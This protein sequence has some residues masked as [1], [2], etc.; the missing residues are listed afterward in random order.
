MAP[1]ATGPS[2]V[3]NGKLDRSTPSP[4]Y[5]GYDHMTWYVGNAKQVVSWYTTRMGFQ[6]IAYQGLETG[7]RYTASYVISN[8]R[9]KFV[10]TSPIRG[11]SDLENASISEKKRVEEMH[12][13]LDQHGDGVKD[14]AFEVDDARA[15]YESAVRKGAKSVQEPSSL[16]DDDGEVI[17]ATIKT[18]GDTTHTFVQRSHYRGV[19]L[20]SYR[21]VSA[22][23]P[24]NKY[25]PDISLEEIDHCVGNQDWNQMNAVVDL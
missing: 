24:A 19:F 6:I 5:R 2:T 17:V 10:V 22:E 8:G 13:H 18:F 16:S 15:I 3:K 1:S 11:S 20:P 25:L 14:V 9:A 7:S 12:K 23:D 4:D 21:K